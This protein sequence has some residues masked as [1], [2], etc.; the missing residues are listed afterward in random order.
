[1]RELTATISATS[2][3][4]SSSPPIVIFKASH[5]HLW[6]TPIPYLFGSLALMLLLI[7]VA[8]VLL[9]CSYHQRSYGGR[10]DH[11]DDED[12]QKPPKP[13]SGVDLH[14][15]E[16]KIVV[17]MAGDDNPTYLATPVEVVVIASGSSATSTH[18]D[19]DDDHGDDDHGDDQDQREI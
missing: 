9:L 15:D 13:I 19:D 10:P 3:P 6:N 7:S 8:L 17:I 18:H 11:G 4:A 2:S 1:M 12:D 14:A 5:K 16:P